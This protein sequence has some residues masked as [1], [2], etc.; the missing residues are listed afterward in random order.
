MNDLS[1]PPPAPV[2]PPP[3]EPPAEPARRRRST[4]AGP[5]GVLD[6]GTTKVSCL[7]GRTDADGGLRV[8]GFGW[9]RGRGV[10]AGGIIDLD[11]AERAIRRAVAAAEEMAEHRLHAVTVNLTCGQPESRLFD[12]QWPV[13]GRA[14]AESDIKRV[15]QE[16]RNR[17][18]CE[19]RETIHVL[20]LGFSVDDT[21]GVGDPRGMH[22][23]RLAARL[24]VVDAACGALRNLGATVQRCE[25]D[26]AELVSAPMAAGL[27]VLV[28]DERELGATVVDM[29][30]G[31]TGM[32]VFSEGQLLHTAQL[33]LG[34]AHVTND[35]ARLLSTPVAHAE[36]LKTLY[37]HAEPCADDERELLPVPLVGEEE[38][39]IAKVPRS[40]VVEIIRP[41]LEETFELVRDR[42]DAAGLTRAA[43]RVVL[44]GG[45]SQLVG[46]RE[47][48]GRILGRQVR[49]GR[50]SPLRGLPD[51]ACGPAF[52]TAAG[53]L[54]WAAG[55]GRPLAEIGPA[56]RPPT[57]RLRRFVAYLR[58]RV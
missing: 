52:A 9:Q 40:R 16:G 24:H 44:T 22:C 19:G 33:P 47:M 38:H 48:A 32:A 17:A 18:L 58:E 27:A 7:I 34:G 55:E 26:I 41:R 57:G 54:A 53:L 12:V 5:F 39:H 45:A 21:A 49:L 14:V 1:R 35:I 3:A 20:P 11:E 56:D 6:V 29:G 46:V 15:A 43:G 23:E 2:P 10:R 50:P 51:P 37:G 13:G 30:G 28:E 8:L 4:R 31:T 36:R 42:L 25:L